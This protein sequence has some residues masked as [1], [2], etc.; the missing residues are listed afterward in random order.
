MA[1]MPPA[2]AKTALRRLRAGLP[3]DVKAFPCTL[4]PLEFWE[5][6]TSEAYQTHCAQLDRNERTV[7]SQSEE[8][9]DGE[10]VYERTTRFTP[11][12]NPLPQSV[13]SFIGCETLSFEMRE[14][15]WKNAC[16]AAHPSTYESVPNVLADRIRIRG[17]CWADPNPDG[18][19]SIVYFKNEVSVSVAFVGDRIGKAILAG[20]AKAL[21]ET[22][23][24]AAAFHTMKRDETSGGVPSKTPKT[25]RLPRIGSSG[26]GSSRRV[27]MQR[28]GTAA[29]SRRVLLTKTQKSIPALLAAAVIDASQSEMKRT[30]LGK[31]ATGTDDVAF[32]VK[33]NGPLRADGSERGRPR[34]RSWLMCGSTCFGWGGAGAATAGASASPRRNLASEF[35]TTTTV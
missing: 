29:R 17:S 15:W 26:V 6:T 4:T 31:M 35:A 22:P 19:G 5:V 3:K 34:G 1:A 11:S 8:V 28:H 9:V 14:R 2:R 23:K 16:D 32:T 21:A 24:R 7:L 30:G 25:V 12:E 10:V 13:R 18:G 20:S 27:L 33:G